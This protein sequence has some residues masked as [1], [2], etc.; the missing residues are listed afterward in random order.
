VANS[1]KIRRY[2]D[3]Y[4]SRD[5][6]SVSPTFPYGSASGFS[7]TLIPGGQASDVRLRRC[8]AQVQ[9]CTLIHVFQSLTV[10]VEQ[11]ESTKDLPALIVVQLSGGFLPKKSAGK[12]EGSHKD[13]RPYQIAVCECAP[14]NEKTPVHLYAFPCDHPQ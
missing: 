11:I 3:G 10:T 12:G 4:Q 8:A 2:R 6:P 14:A 9:G 5:N 1:L 13:T 7:N